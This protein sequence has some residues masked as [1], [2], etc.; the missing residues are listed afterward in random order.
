MPQPT[1][2]SVPTQVASKSTPHTVPSPKET[3]FRRLLVDS[4]EKLSGAE[5]VDQIMQ[6]FRAEMVSASSRISTALEEATQSAA[7]SRMHYDMLQQV[8]MSASH[9]VWERAAMASELATYKS[10]IDALIRVSDR[11]D[12]DTVDVTLLRQTLA[13]EP[14][15]PVTMPTVLGFYPDRAYRAGQF[16]APEGD[17]TLIW[18]FTGWSLVDHGP[19]A[20]GIIEPVFIVKDRALPKSS[21]EIERHVKFERYLE[22][23]YSY[24]AA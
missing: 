14:L 17:V 16:T 5:A 10:I 24:A 13:M 6:L 22:H 12:G 3:A 18:P 19:G 1:L 4:L 23:T 2:A 21:I 11:C 7:S 15:K 8:Q 9:G 20:P